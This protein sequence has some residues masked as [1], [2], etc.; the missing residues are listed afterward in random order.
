MNKIPL[1][2]QNTKAKNLPVDVCVF[3]GFGRLSPAAV[4][5]ADWRFDSGVKLWIHVSSIVTYL[6]ESFLSVALEQFQTM[7]WIVD[8]LLFLIE[9][10]QT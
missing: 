8:A 7:L 4:H 1:A 3:S 10:E 5:L 2:S 6:R 9:C